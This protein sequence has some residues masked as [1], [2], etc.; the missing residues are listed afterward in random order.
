VISIASEILT[1]FGLKDTDFEININNRKVMNYIFKDVFSLSEE[2]THKLSKLIDK[3]NKLEKK[4]FEE[5]AVF[6]QWLNNIIFKLVL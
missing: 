5:G 3:K 4:F 2:D 6:S 1:T